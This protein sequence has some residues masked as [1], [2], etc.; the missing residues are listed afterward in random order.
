[1]IVGYITSLEENFWQF[2]TYWTEGLM[3]IYFT[4]AFGVSLHGVAK[5]KP[6]ASKNEGIN[7]YR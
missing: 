1:M 4:F 2:L 3:V 5:S 6:S 7:Y